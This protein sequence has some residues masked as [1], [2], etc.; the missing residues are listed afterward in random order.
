MH[1]PG[2]CLQQCSVPRRLCVV[3]VAG[4]VGGVGRRVWGSGVA[5]RNEPMFYVHGVE[6]REGVAPARFMFAGRRVEG[7]HSHARRLE[8]QAAC[9]SFPSFFICLPKAVER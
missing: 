6:R 3:P 8:S 4:G 9:P 2:C 7:G 5:R 1:T